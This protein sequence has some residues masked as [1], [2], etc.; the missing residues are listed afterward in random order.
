MSCSVINI[1]NVISVSH[2][3]TETYIYI[4]IYI[5]TVLKPRL[6]VLLNTTSYFDFKYFWNRH[7]I[8]AITDFHFNLPLSILCIDVIDRFLIRTQ[9]CVMNGKGKVKQ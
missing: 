9:N 1:Y 3:F 4:Y 2:A 8:I 5:Y 6:Q 7:T